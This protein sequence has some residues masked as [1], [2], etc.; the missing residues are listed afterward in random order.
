MQTELIKRFLKKDIIRNLNMLYFMED[1]P[2]HSLERTD[3]SVLMRGTS[4]HRWVYISSP[5]EQELLFLSA[6]LTGE[7]RYFAVIEDWMHP[8][9]YM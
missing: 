8:Q 9:H 3:D 2:V 7:D 1:N 5:D 6:R 4:D